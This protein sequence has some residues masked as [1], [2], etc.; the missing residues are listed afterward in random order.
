MMTRKTVFSLVA[1]LALSGAAVLGPKPL[2]GQ[3][4]MGDFMFHPPRV[5]LTLNFGYGMPRAGSDIF[6][7]VDTI[8]TLDKGDFRAP[9]IGGGLSVFLND[10]MDLAFEFSFARS[11]TWSEYVDW[12]DDDDLPI[13][14]ETQFTRVPLTVSLR[15]FLMDRGRE[16]GNL[17]WIPTTWAPYVGAGGGTM[18]YKFEQVG[19]FVDIEDLSIFGNSYV[20]QGWGWVGHVF[21]G[22]QWVLSPEWVL[23]AEGRYSL[24][25]ADL[26]RPTYRLYEPIDLSG[27]QGSVGFGVRF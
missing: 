20:S 5:T 6:Q 8:F 4:S 18:M 10:R 24:A 23:T 19:D 21:G 2:S 3:E 7:D 13:E 26:E 12:V 25:S 1:F 9:A 15:Y 16:I 22:V 14:Q 11:S 27:F 17:S